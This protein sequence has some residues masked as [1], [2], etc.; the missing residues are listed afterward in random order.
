MQRVVITLIVLFTIW[1]IVR[2]IY[3]PLY[4]RLPL[5]IALVV[6]YLLSAYVLLP[7]IVHLGLTIVRRGRIPR[8][9]RAGDGLP[10]DP[11]NILLVGSE[12]ELL[13]AFSKAG[14][15]EADHLNV[16]NSLKMFS[17]FTFNRPY[18]RAPFR[19]LYLFARRQ[20]HGFQEAIG[21][22]PRSRH[23]I[24][25]WAANLDPDADPSDFS[26]WS[27]KH[28]IDPAKPLIW[29]GAAS[30]D[31]GIGLTQLTYQVTHR[32]DRNVDTEREY[33]LQA[34]RKANVIEDEHYV[35]SGRI[36]A[37][38]Y[39][40]DGRILTAKLASLPENPA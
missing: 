37:G 34:L 33:I 35:D 29:V 38:K 17:A 16:K 6:T 22:S 11:V 39:I 40:S 18:L 12:Q 3:E 24:R 10:A 14:W 27:K 32:I 9:T 7:R 8:A 20:D 36:V 4:A 1:L 2:W 15:S 28:A 26:Y 19:S 25:F 23:H 21:N 31:L 30:K 5:F 13:A